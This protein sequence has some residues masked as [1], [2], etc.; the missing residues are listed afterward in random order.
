MT[1]LFNQALIADIT[2]ENFT[3][4]VLLGSQRFPVALVFW[5]ETHPESMQLLAAWE[6][7][8]AQY[9]GKLI[10]GKVE[11]TKQLELTNRLGASGKLPLC[12]IVHKQS[13]VA[14]QDSYHSQSVCADLLHEFLELDPAEEKHLNAIDAM[15]EGDYARAETLL[16]EAINL[17]SDNP[18]FHL[19]LIDAFLKQ[20]KLTDAQTLFNGLPQEVQE[21]AKGR[22]FKGMLYFVEQLQ[23]APPIA[24]LPTQLAKTPNKEKVL[25]PLA[26]YFIA[27]DH[28]EQAVQALLKAFQLELA[29][30]IAPPLSEARADLIRLFSM[31]EGFQ[32]DQVKRYRQMMQSLLV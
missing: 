30:D 3:D 5:S 9:P 8:A 13:F 32:P 20:R 24:D 7:V 19:D 2:S 6:A 29:Q 11:V 26:H 23:S 4:V 18:E 31:L 12:K 22:Y 27:S 21:S 14:L 28:T 10:V 1:P 25:L 16:R 15:V 17:F